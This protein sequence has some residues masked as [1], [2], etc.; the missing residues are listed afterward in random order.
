MVQSS[1]LLGGQVSI[2]L[3]YEALLYCLQFP[4]GCETLFINGR[5][6]VPEGGDYDLSKA[7]QRLKGTMPIRRGNCLI[8]HQGVFGFEP[9]TRRLAELPWGAISWGA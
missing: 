3:S 4:W 2:S 6:R 1:I 5:F 9:Q 7:V 8:A